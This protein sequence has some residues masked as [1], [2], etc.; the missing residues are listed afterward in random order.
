MRQLCL[1]GVSLLLLCWGVSSSVLAA[2]TS[3]VADS[4]IQVE[5]DQ[6]WLEGETNTY[7]AIGGVRITG[8]DLE[9]QADEVSWAADSG[10]AV[11]SGDVNL[12]RSGT[13]LEGEFM[14]FNL[15][16][17]LGELSR[18]QVLLEEDNFHFS[19][20]RIIR[21]GERDFSVQNGTFTSCDP[22][23]P[24]WQFV[25]SSM[26][27]HNARW[28]TAKHVRFHIAD[29][30]ILY[31]PYLVY[32]IRYERESGFLEPEIG[33]SNSAGTELSL[34]YYWA[35]A[36][37]MDATID[38]DYLSRIGLGKGLEYRY[39]LPNLNNGVL[40]GY[41]VNG[42][43]DNPNSHALSWQ[44]KGWLPGK[45]RMLADMEY[46]SDKDFL[47]DFGAAADEYNK[48]LTESTL[49]FGRTWQ[50]SF[51]GIRFD[52]TQDLVNN[53]KSVLQRLPRLDLS[54][55]RSRL[56]STPLFVGVDTTTTYFWREEGQDGTRLLLRPLL[57]ADLHLGDYLSL[58][59]EVAFLQR[60]YDTDQPSEEDSATGNYELALRLKSELSRVFHVDGE[61]LENVRHLLEPRVEYRYRPD[62]DQDALPYFDYLDRRGA[63]NLLELALVNRWTARLRQDEGAPYYHEFLQIR[64]AQAY[65]LDEQRREVLPGD[66]RRRPWGLFRTEV[67]LHP[68]RRSFIDLDALFDVNTGGLTVDRRVEQFNARAGYTDDAGNRLRLGYYYSGEEEK[69]L[70][71][72]I[73][74]S[75]LNPLFLGFTQRFDFRDEK[76]LE[77][78]LRAEYRS[79]CWSVALTLT[80]RPDEKSFLVSFAL[81]GFGQLAEMGGGL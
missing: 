72:N 76:S 25:A 23:D 28:A 69:Y 77:R 10:E 1:R 32:P 66:E 4:P 34:V 70:H 8:E 62:E 22:L 46:V 7:R 80:E 43:S 64:L 3:L 2:T 20:E 40:N 18:G 9:L 61:R 31:L 67:V 15:N 47:E 71:G 38:L 27:V 12:Y 48:D 51:A 81:G 33:Y 74:M 79:E 45:V 24:D 36:Q 58:E 13:R 11:A 53:D 26:R 41:H 17:G 52:Y 35:I 50:R 56:W 39:A 29:I 14:N 75:L 42:Y 73:E 78:S 19:G 57:A 68:T 37:N 5:A 44:H 21:T 60:Y 63:E 6:F 54:R 55:V 16:T 49:A 59:P 65:D 30:P